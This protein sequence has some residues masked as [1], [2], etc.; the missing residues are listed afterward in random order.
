M[1]N[2]KRSA[3]EAYDEEFAGVATLIAKIDRGLKSHSGR[4]SLTPWNW[5]WVGD[6][7]E[8]RKQLKSALYSLTGEGEE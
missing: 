6:L 4:Q 2:T 8:A 3:Q 1:Q 7:A 5:G